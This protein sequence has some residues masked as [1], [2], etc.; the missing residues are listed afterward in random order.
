[1]RFLT[2]LFHSK[3]GDVLTG[4]VS[5]KEATFWPSRTPPISQDFQKLWGE[6]NVPIFQTLPLFDANHHSLAVDIG[7]FQANRFRNP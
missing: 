1:M 5:W 4:D 2:C 3:P 7:R 6:H